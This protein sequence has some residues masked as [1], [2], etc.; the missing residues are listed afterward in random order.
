VARAVERGETTPMRHYQEYGRRERR[1]LS[2]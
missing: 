2:C 1:S